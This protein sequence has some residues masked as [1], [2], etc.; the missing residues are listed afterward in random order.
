MDFAK[1]GECVSKSEYAAIEKL[2]QEWPDFFEKTFMKMR[3]SDGVLGKLYR[4]IHN[5]HAMEA[6]MKNDYKSSVLLDYQLD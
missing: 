2:V 1:H 3:K 6:F 4:D 5:E